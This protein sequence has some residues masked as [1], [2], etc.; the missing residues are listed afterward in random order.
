MPTQPRDRAPFPRRVA[1]FNR[2][3]ANPVVRLVAGWLPPLA[4]VRHRGRVTGRNYTTPVV[5]F[6][7]NDGLIVAVL[8]GAGSDWVRNLLVAGRAQVERRGAAHEYVQPRL[9]GSDEGSR[10]VPAVVRGP[11]RL[12]RV[13]TFI[14]LK[15]PAPPPTASP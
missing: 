4:I 10:L 7:T 8:Y 11:F 9:V 2:T 14:R 12:L 6:G 1:R 15:S 3:F 5:A 13:G